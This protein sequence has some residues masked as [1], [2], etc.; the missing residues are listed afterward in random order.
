MKTLKA[1]SILSPLLLLTLPACASD[2]GSVDAVGTSG[3]PTSA[4]TPGGEDT[5]GAIDSGDTNESGGPW[6]TAGDTS[7][8]M[9]TPATCGDGVKDAGEWCDEG[10]ANGIYGGCAVGCAGPG[11]HCGDGEMQA[12]YEDCD[13]ENAADG[14]G[15]NADCTASGTVLWSTTL[16]AVPM[17]P[18]ADTPWRVKGVV[19]ADDGGA[20]AF[21][22]N[23]ARISPVG[24]KVW[25]HLS[26]YLMCLQSAGC[27]ASL[28]RHGDG[29]LHRGDSAG[30]RRL[31]FI[32]DSGEILQMVRPELEITSVYRTDSH[33]IVS[34]VE[35]GVPF[36]R[37][38]DAETFSLAE[39]L[40]P[41]AWAYEL[42][43]AVVGAPLIFDDEGFYYLSGTPLPYVTRYDNDEG[44]V[45]WTS[46]I[47][48]DSASFRRSMS[49]AAKSGLYMSGNAPADVANNSPRIRLYSA[50]PDTSAGAILMD[51]ALDVAQLRN[52]SASDSDLFCVVI[53]AG[54][55]LHK[56]DKTGTLVWE[57]ELSSKPGD[58]FVQAN[59]D[60]T[61]F[62][63]NHHA[64]GSDVWKLSQ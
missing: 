14:D 4:G 36:V 47:L 56:Y 24:E 62:V 33:I 50:T 31:R 64:N 32:A 18:L 6:G 15:C 63:W 48:R 60:G 21:G 28:L 11:P 17:P 23:V 22:Q 16:T 49:F 58:Y 40:G 54:T 5:D 51:Q 46:N 19:A 41:S 13:D 26:L 61:T 55:H 10:P 9:G 20:V 42:P 30:R 45:W 7:P 1:I 53:E 8:P 25:E 37:G 34:G 39:D 29:W 43:E 35:E 27:E 12:G 44:Q 3:A 2:G 57:R 38:Y 59:P 52:C